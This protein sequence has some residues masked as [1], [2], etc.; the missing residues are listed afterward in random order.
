MAAIR[1]FAENML[2]G[3][4]GPLTDLQRTY[5]TRIQ[6]NVAR[7]GRIIVQLLDW[8]RLDT[9]RIELRMEDVSIQHIAAI[10]A[11]SLQMVA[12]E[13]NVS[14]AIESIEPLPAV[15]GD[16]DKLEQILWNLIGNAIKFTPPGGRI[17]VEFCES[18]A[19]FVQTCV[20]DTGCGI[21]SPHLSN[22]FDEFSKVPSS[23]PASQGA[24]LGLCITKTLV[25][26]HHGVIWVESQAGTG[27]RFYFTLPIAAS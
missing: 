2:D 23:M 15:R 19:G 13:K 5:L 14:L 3:V 27:S 16:R 1:S 24:Q 9:R 10:A 17:T 11:D 20:A 7:L 12:S 25:N 21:D 18:P 26:M 4:T 22:I 8:S 6:H